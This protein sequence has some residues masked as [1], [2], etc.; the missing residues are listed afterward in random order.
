[1]L[2]LGET[3]RRAIKAFIETIFTDPKKILQ[4]QDLDNR[5]R[6]L[7]TQNNIMWGVIG[8]TIITLLA[9]VVT[10]IVTAS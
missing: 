5:V 8:G 1:M 9:L 7:E 6:S 10:I 2:G 4:V 3:D